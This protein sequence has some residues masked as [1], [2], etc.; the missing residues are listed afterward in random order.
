MEQ[1]YQYGFWV[2]CFVALL[3]ALLSGSLIQLSDKEE[4][5]RRRKERFDRLL[6][7]EF[8]QDIGYDRY[9]RIYDRVDFKEYL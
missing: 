8:C 4:I 5:K 2:A 7:D 9:W 6:R 3:L 1:F